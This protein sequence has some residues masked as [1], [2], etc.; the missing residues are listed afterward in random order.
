M[1]QEG[2]SC[3][4]SSSWSKVEELSHADQHEDKMIKYQL[5]HV[6]VLILFKLLVR[7]IKTV[8]VDNGLTCYVN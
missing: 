8:Q 6:A 1:T 3:S 5:A 4:G 7:I 2:I